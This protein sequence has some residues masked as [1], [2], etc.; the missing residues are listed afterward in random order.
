MRPLMVLSCFLGALVIAVA[1]TGCGDS[2]NAEP[3]AQPQKD[4]EKNPD[5]KPSTRPKPNVEGN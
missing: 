5:L 1:L 4:S 3:A 2:K